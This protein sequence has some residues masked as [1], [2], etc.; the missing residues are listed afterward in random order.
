MKVKIQISE[1]IKEPYA[2]IYC[3]RM[4]K[5]IQQLADQLSASDSI[6]TVMDG[7]Q[8][9]PLKPEDIYML[10]T[11]NEQVTV[12]CEKKSYTTKKPLY[13]MEELL[14]KNF[15]RIS[16]STIINLKEISSVEPYFSGTM[17]L[18][19]KNGNKDYISRKYLPK[20]KQYLG[21]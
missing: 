3:D 8:M 2:V 1:D 7:E 4:T 9:I 19:L 20:F 21:L 10:R 18:V 16:K 5:E 6:I 12:Y 17:L 15:M 14:G 13:K 11:E